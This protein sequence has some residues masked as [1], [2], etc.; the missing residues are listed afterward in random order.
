MY[1]DR[2]FDY[3]HPPAVPEGDFD[4]GEGFRDKAQVVSG[5]VREDPANSQP[6]FPGAAA[7]FVPEDTPGHKYVGDPVTAT[8]ADSDE[9]TYSLDGADKASFYIVGSSVTDD[10]DAARRELMR[11]QLQARLGSQ[12][13]K[14]WT[15]R[16]TP[17]TTVSRFRRL[18]LPA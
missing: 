3:P 5:V 4:S 16:L 1:L 8:D 14:S 10:D 18:T 2:T 13:L 6:Q 17:D 11:G 15:T 12:R 9:L 7:R